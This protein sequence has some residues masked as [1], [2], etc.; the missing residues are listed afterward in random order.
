MSDH[1]L[2]AEEIA[3]WCDEKSDELHAMADKLRKCNQETSSAH[4]R[5]RA[6]T[7]ANVAEAIR[8]GTA[9][10]TTEKQGE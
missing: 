9:R 6:F 10:P 5:Q 4:V 2:T 8:S 3:Q 1:K 7:Y